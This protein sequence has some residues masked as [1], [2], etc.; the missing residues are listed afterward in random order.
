MDSV[1]LE[2]IHYFYA[3]T[4]GTYKFPNSVEGDLIKQAKKEIEANLKKQNKCHS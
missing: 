2:N 3:Q 1:F 4:D